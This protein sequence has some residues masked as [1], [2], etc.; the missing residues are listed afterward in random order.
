MNQN[1]SE[2]EK[3]E[4]IVIAISTDRIGPLK[5][6]AEKEGY[7]FRVISDADT[8]ISKEYNVFGRPIDY[9]MIKF[10]L[11]I[12]TSYLIDSNGKIVWRYVGNKT[13]RPS[14]KAILEAI[15][16]IYKKLFKF[17]LG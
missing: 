5:K 11:A 12:P 16:Q 7:K 1:I 13:D 6:L 14:I 17:L 9:D 15:D 4:I 8:K 10:E 2:F 3:R